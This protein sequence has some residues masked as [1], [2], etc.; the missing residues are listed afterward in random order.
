MPVEI[1]YNLC[2]KCLGCAMIC[3]EELY[4]IEG[5]K[6]KIAEGC[7]DCGNCIECCPVKAISEI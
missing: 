1:D 5:E 4:Y 2:G 3:P 7:T 6:L